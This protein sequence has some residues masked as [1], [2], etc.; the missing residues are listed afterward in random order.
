MKATVK[1]LLESVLQQL[2]DS[3][4]LPKE[5]SVN[6]KVEYSKDKSHGDY[7][8]NVAMMLAKP[9]KRSP[10]EIASLIIDSM[11]DHPLIEKIEIAGPGFI[12]FY[13][14]AKERAEMIAH[15]I[16]SGPKYGQLNLGKGCKVLLE[17][18]SANPTGPLH[19]GHGRSAAY[20]ATLANLLDVAGFDV[21]R[22]YYVNDAGRQMNILAVSVWLRYLE[23]A[24]E[25]VVF[26]ANG[27]RGAYVKDIAKE[28]FDKANTRYVRPWHAVIENLPADEPSGGDKE[29][30]IDAM[31]HRS[32]KLLGEA[33]FEY[34]H[35]QA[36]QNVRED[37]KEDLKA[38]GVEYDNWFSERS[39]F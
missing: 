8:T 11:P 27:Y 25:P 28:I 18:V 17:F 4:H 36:L 22:E 35:A 30:Y 20:G 31:I 6:I 26:P 32:Q 21:T 2:I 7:A 14:K 37:I 15:V 19:V 3:N 29:H 16:Q 10:R 5:A 9:C 12:N 33:D 34:F 24:G 38:F 13:M 23:Q 39:L 1:A